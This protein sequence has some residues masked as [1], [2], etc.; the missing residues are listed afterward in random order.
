MFTSLVAQS[1]SGCSDQKETAIQRPCLI[2]SMVSRTVALVG[3]LAIMLLLSVASLVMG[4]VCAAWVGTTA[5][6]V[7]GF[8]IA[9]VS[10]IALI[11]S[12]LTCFGAMKDLFSSDPQK[13][14]AF[15]NPK[16]LAPVFD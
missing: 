5:S 9:V 15:A 12:G 8:C 11:L 1:V 10:L 3:S 16:L 6:G 4:I 2:E 13:E 14:T 7:I